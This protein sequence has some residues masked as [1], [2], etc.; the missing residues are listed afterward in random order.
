MMLWVA[1]YTP[2]KR[3]LRQTTLDGL[4]SLENG[5]STP[6]KAMV[7]KLQVGGAPAKHT[8][9]WK[10]PE[11]ESALKYMALTFRKACNST[12]KKEILQRLKEAIHSMRLIL[13]GQ[14]RVKAEAVKWYLSLNM[15]FCKSTSSGVKTD[16]AETFCPEVFKSIKTHELDDQFHVQYNQIVPQIDEFQRNGSSCV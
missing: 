6:K 13:E 2:C 4:S 9:Y 14:T 11:I 3:Q 10:T 5:P 1:S 12:S 15:N 7:V 16:L 8:K